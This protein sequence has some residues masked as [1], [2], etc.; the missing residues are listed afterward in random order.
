MNMMPGMMGM[1]PMPPAGMPTPFLP[2]DRPPGDA[3]QVR[4]C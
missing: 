2:M 1:M 3:S 4:L